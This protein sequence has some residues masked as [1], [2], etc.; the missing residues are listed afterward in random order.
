MG[1]IS[2]LFN[3]LLKF[4]I[5][6]LIIVFLPN[7]PPHTTFNFEHFDVTPAKDLVGPLALNTYLDNAERLL[8]DRLY[9]PEHILKRGNDLYVSVCTGQILKING[10]HIT[11]LAKFGE[12]CEYFELSKCGRPVGLEFDVG[13]GNNL[14]AADASF[15]IWQVNLDSGATK[16]LVSPWSE[17]GAENRRKAKFF[18]SLA[19]HSSGDVYFTDSS[20]DFGLDD[21]L[22][23]FLTNP[24]GRVFHYSRAKNETTV[25]LDKISFANGI[26]LSPNEDFLV[27]AETGRGRL[28]KYYLT[29][30]NKGSWEVFVDGLPGTPDNL[31]PELNGIWVP[32]VTPADKDQPS[33]I[34]SLAQVPLIRKFLLRLFALIEL[35]FKLIEKFMPNDYAKKAIHY[36]GAQ[37]PALYLLPNRSTIVFVDWKGNIVTSLHGSDLSAGRVSHVLVDGDYLILGSPYNRFLARIKYPTEVRKIIADHAALNQA[38]RAAPVTE[39]PTTKPPPTTTSTTTVK[40]STTPPPP[41]T[42]SPTT[43]PLPTTTPT[44]APPPTTQKPVTQAPTT[45]APT[46][47]PPPPPS[48]TQT[49]TTKPS[50][51]PP[52]ST[53]KSV[54]QPPPQGTQKPVTQP[55]PQ[56]T[57]KPITQ[58]PPPTK[59]STGAREAPPQ[60]DPN[61]IPKEPAPIHEKSDDNVK[62][63]MPP[64]KVIKKDGVHGEL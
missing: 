43:T 34:F 37:Q 63:K 4:L 21:A 30:P 19:V 60:R 6:F 10:N 24:C 47:K 8:V 64:L 59:R 35:P 14:I 56:A 33:L 26:I 25:L 23:A 39:A 32:L 41:T 15:G 29:G 28:I 54:A 20:S 1:C 31:T 2:Y 62:Q 12:A 16:L 11:H 45:Q 3:K 49:P 52:A 22:Y 55:S 27:V 42:S 7:L 5:F 40:P 58:S 44:T 48:S 51:P 36:I 53:Q 50:P 17:Y 57:E 18:N 61:L 38:K 46:T 9:G 13:N